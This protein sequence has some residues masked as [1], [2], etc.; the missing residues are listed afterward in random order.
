MTNKST[1]NQGN[2]DQQYSEFMH[3][4]LA[5]ERKIRGYVLCL[6]SNWADAD[7]ILQDVATVMWKKYTTCESSQHFLNWALRIA[8]FEVL[9]YLKKKKTRLPAY[10]LPVLEALE[11][12]AAR[13]LQKEDRRSEALQACITR[14][15]QRDQELVRLRYELDTTVRAVAESVG[16]S[17][18]GV[19]KSLNRIHLHLMHCI[20]QRLAQEQRL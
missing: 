11:A 19:Y 1:T 12:K 8:H 4:Y 18:D 14:L 16:R 10:S 9:N 17:I 15:M 20:R 5:H 6:V 13:A 3:L 2:C 7:D